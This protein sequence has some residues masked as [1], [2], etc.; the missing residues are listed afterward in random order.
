MPVSNSVSLVAKGIAPILFKIAQTIGLSRMPSL[1][2]A[3]EIIRR[4][5]KYL[6]PAI[7]ATA[8]GITISEMGMLM[9]ANARKKKR[10]INPANT[11]A[12]RRSMRRLH[13]F[14]KLASRVSAQLSHVGHRRRASTRRCGK[15]RRNP[16]SC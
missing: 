1:Q 2:R 15:C 4:M 10:R 5:A 7:T 16:C 13:S 8:L 9:A 11:K 3:M 6:S 12:L 14:D